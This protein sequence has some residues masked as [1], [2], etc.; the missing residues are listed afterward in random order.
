MYVLVENLPSRPP[1][2]LGL[3]LDPDTHTQMWEGPLR[4]HSGKGEAVATAASS[5]QKQQATLI[6]W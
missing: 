5:F 3:A 4:V 6:G 2:H 1:L